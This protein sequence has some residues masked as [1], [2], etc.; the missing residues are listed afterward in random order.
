MNGKYEYVIG[1]NTIDILSVQWV[2][3]HLGAF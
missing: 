3:V 1:L 2:S